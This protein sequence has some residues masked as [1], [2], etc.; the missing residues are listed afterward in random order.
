[1]NVST[2]LQAGPAGSPGGAGLKASAMSFLVPVV[3]AYILLV[4]FLRRRRERQMR[5]KFGY[6]TRD[7]LKNMTNDDAF[8][9]QNAVAELE[10]PWVFKKSLQFALFKVRCRQ[11]ET[12]AGTRASG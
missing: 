7:S 8:A 1:M 10:F 2:T 5:L 4:S 9:I 12:E 3:L 6:T 11:V